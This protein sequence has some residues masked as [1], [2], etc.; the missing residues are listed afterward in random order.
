MTITPQLRMAIALAALA[1]A[2]LGGWVVHGWQFDAQAKEALEK[3]IET[4]DK[5][6]VV[7]DTASIGHEADKT[8]LRT[9]YVT[10]TE[11]VEKIIEKPIYSNVCFDADGLRELSAAIGP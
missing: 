11:T 3:G 1:M 5:R 8:K 10:I 7:A 9:Q 2:F 4:A 6:A